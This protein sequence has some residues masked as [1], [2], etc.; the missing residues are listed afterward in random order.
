MKKRIIISIILLLVVLLIAFIF[1]NSL[2]NAADSAVQSGTVKEIVDSVLA[3]FGYDDGIDTTLLRG[4][5]HFGEFF[6]LGAFLA[7]EIL[8][9]FPLTFES[10]SA[11]KF[12]IYVSPTAISLIVACI[13]E[14][15]QIFSP[16]RVCDVLDV[17]VDTAGSASANILVLLIGIIIYSIKK[18]KS[19]D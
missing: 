18:E 8:F 9:V 10:Q 13:D 1:S 16:G 19:K 12:I 6:M 4:L 15:I 17:L 3:L 14:F 7:A 11:K 2:K 5:A